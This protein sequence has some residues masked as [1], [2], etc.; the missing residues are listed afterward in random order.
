MTGMKLKYTNIFITLI[1]L[2]IFVFSAGSAT[3]S[4]YSN[5]VLALY[6]ASDGY[7][8]SNNPFKWLAEP[9]LK[10]IG[11]KIMYYNIES[12]IPKRDILKDVRA[13]ITWYNSGLVANKQFGLDYIEF[14]K[15]SVDSGCKLI[16][17]NSFGAYGYKENGTEKWDLQNEINVLFK[18]MGFYFK[19]FWTDDP[20]KIK[21]IYKDEF[22]TEKDAKQ[23]VNFSK[24]YQQIVPLRNDVKTYLTIKRT[25]KIQGIGD[26]SSSVILTSKNGAFALERYVLS[27]NKLMLNGPEFLK[28]A[29]FYD[30]GSQ[31]VCVIIG[32]ISNKESAIM[33]FEYAFNYAKIQH[34]FIEAEKLSQVLADDLQPYS[35]VIVATETVRDIPFN[36]VRDYVKR[37]GNL[38]FIKAADLSTQF[39]ELTGVTTYGNSGTFREGFK[40]DPEFCINK[41]NITGK[42]LAIAVRRAALSNCKVL[43]YVLDEDESK[44]YPVMWETTYGKGR[45]LY[46]NTNLLLNVKKAYRGA[47][48]QSIHYLCNGFVTG[49]V[50]VGLMMIDDLPAP[51]WNI[52]YQLNKLEHYKNLLKNE[53]DPVRQE[54]IKKIIKNLQGYSNIT[55]TNFVNNIW[56]K[57]IEAFGKQF[58]FQ[59]STYMI[60]NYNNKTTLEKNEDAFS[61]N[62]IY[63]AEDSLPIKMGFRILN[64]DWE[65]GLHGYNHMSLTVKKPEFYESTPW[66]DKATMVKALSSVKQEWSNIFGEINQPF[67]YVAPHNIIDSTGLSAIADVFPSITVISALYVSDQGESEQEFDWTFDRRF[68]QLPRISS[69]YLMNPANKMILLD[70]IHN[71]GVISH[72]V[73][74]D[75]VFDETRSSGFTG[76]DTMKSA[77][78]ED[79]AMIKKCMPSMRWMTSKDAYSEFLFYNAAKIKVKESDKN[80]IVESSGGTGKFLYFRMRLRK[81]QKIKTVQNCQI[82]NANYDSGDII[83]KTNEHLSRIVL[84]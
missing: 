33:N 63:L 44:N 5:N 4:Q 7:T 43:A 1:L 49:M 81:G 58:G 32:D 47:I 48:I 36:P 83:L 57:D 38:I 77:F 61:I 42:D 16:I 21:I 40:I 11:L 54:A 30:D 28:R 17:L 79:F 65:L 22:I 10:K 19:G 26:G 73:H 82:V 78:T 13:I 84:N 6:K 62:D 20:G 68:F 53:S 56:I 64:N 50:N 60:F 24:H 74:P 31:D 45:V 69:G 14:L 75:D 80:I 3:A 12:G 2:I 18:K 25:D 66:P 41:A 29:L 52:Y 34:T 55:D 51:R 76:W 70:A 23:D 39:K 46:W 71:F 15:S 72:F 9:E 67:S 35:A 59:Y 37:G 8:D 27:G